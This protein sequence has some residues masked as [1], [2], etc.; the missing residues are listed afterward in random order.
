M[1][2]KTDLQALADMRIREAKVLL[3]AGEWNGAYYLAGYAVE[4]G[5]KA[6]ITKRLNNSDGWREKRFTERCSSHD[7]KV[8]LE[9]ADLVAAMINAGP[10]TPR[11]GQ[12]KDWTEESRYE[13]GKTEALVW[14][15]YE[16]IADPVE[17]ALPWIKSRW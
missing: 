4:G 3:D 15:F 8:L 1:L 10:V 12:V 13:L 14:S 9:L 17:G 11:W 6:C 5:L 7:L 2:R 16:A